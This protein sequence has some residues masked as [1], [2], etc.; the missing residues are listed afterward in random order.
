MT[1]Q[2]SPARKADLRELCRTLARAFSDDPVMTWLLPDE[3]TRTAN[4][5]RVFATMTRHHHLGCG[6]VEVARGGPDIG[7][8]AL[9]DPPNRWRE[10]RLGELAMT[11]TFLRVFGLRAT[12]A[13]AVQ[14]LMKRTHPDRTGIS[15]RSA[16]TPRS[17]A[18]ASGRR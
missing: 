6:G 16:A 5:Y 15:P 2:A 1:P 14:E 12:K 13:R 10:T 9:W 17:A 8:A 11:P 3:G 4:L 18:G 7:A